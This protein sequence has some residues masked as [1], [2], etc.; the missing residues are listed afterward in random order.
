MNDEAFWQ[1]SYFKG[2]KQGNRYIHT[3]T[4]DELPD[5]DETYATAIACNLK[6]VPP[7]AVKQVNTIST[8]THR[9]SMMNKRLPVTEVAFADDEYWYIETATGALAAV[10]NPANSAERFSFSNLHMHHYWEAWL[11]K[12]IGKT[13][14]NAMLI[15]STLGLLLL[16]LTGLFLYARKKYGH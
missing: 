12:Q 11:G 10:S 13:A 6:G 14:K 2:K 9:Y 15:S 7:A 8:F 5:G 1:L 16:A 3:I 4:G